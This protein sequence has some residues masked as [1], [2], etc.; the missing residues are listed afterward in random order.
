[1]QNGSQN[2]RSDAYFT[3]FPVWENC[4][5]YIRTNRGTSCQ[6]GELRRQ[7]SVLKRVM[8]MTITMATTFK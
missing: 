3:Y 7:S 1:M 8:K 5:L 2:S 6:E 4:I